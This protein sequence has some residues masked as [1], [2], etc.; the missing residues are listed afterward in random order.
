MTQLIEL[1]DRLRDLANNPCACDNCKRAAH[2]AGIA[3]MEVAPSARALLEMRVDDPGFAAAE[4]RFHADE[5]ERLLAAYTAIGGKPCLLKQLALDEPVAAVVP[6]PTTYYQI[7]P[8]P[9]PEAFRARIEFY[10]KHTMKPR[11]SKRGRAIE[12]IKR[13]RVPGSYLI[14]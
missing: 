4:Q 8:L 13:P 6:A 3:L 9:D 5:A 12:P 11:W 10:R 1:E 7:T 14:R 2:R